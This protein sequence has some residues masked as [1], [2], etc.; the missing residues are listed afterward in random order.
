M[1]ERDPG[2]PHD[3]A[4]RP[5][6]NEPWTVFVDAPIDGESP[7]P[8]MPLA[9]APLV[10][11][12]AGDPVGG[13]TPPPRRTV[14]AAPLAPHRAPTSA[15]IALVRRRDPS[16]QGEARASDAPAA[17]QL[18][19]DSRVTIERVFETP[20]RVTHRRRPDDR[21]AESSEA[22][23]A[24]SVNITIGRVE[25]RAVSAPAAKPR[26]EAGASQPLGLDEYLKRRGAR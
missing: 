2:P 19:P 8:V 1:M 25:V 24:P 13:G 15:S 4:G 26:A 5:A 16:A 6:A 23:A 3:I 22:P 21:Y 12:D 11:L 14:A 17:P 10:T 9:A 20:S 7:E 18:V